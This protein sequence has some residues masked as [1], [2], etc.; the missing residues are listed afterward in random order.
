MSGVFLFFLTNVDET[1]IFST[2]ATVATARGHKM[3]KYRESLTV[4]VVINASHVN[5]TTSVARTMGS[6]SPRL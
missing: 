4:S 3:V 2:P 6:I 1:E 5:L